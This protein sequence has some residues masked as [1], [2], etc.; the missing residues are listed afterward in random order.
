MENCHHSRVHNVTITSLQAAVLL[1]VSATT[2]GQPNRSLITLFDTAVR[3]VVKDAQPEPVREYA[4]GTYFQRWSSVAGPVSVQHRAFPAPETARKVLDDM[5]RALSVPTRRLEGLGDGAFLVAP[6]NPN[7]ERRLNF[8]RGRVLVEVAA[9][10]EDNVRRVAARLLEVVNAALKA[11]EL[12]AEVV[13]DSRALV[14]Q[15]VLDSD[16]KVQRTTVHKYASQSLI[17][18]FDVAIRSMMKDAKPEPVRQQRG[19][20]KVFQRWISDGGQVSVRHFSYPTAE[21][22][23]ILDDMMRTLSIPTR[24]LDGFGDGAFLVAPF[25][26]S[27]QQRLNFVRG[28]VVVEVAAPG[29]EAV[30]RVATRLLQEVNAAIKSG[31]IEDR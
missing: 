6:S 25:T 21:A 13:L 7:G 24:K 26:R 5:M 31:E 1:F 20:G 27:G 23:H 8:V 2:Y 16:Y 10:G 18:R 14:V 17:K 22:A 11:G 30:R 4:R 3:S 9:Q 19:R 28:R 29:E 12:E 15:L